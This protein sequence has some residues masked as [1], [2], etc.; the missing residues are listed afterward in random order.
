LPGNYTGEAGNS[1]RR[2]H[3]C[4]RETRRVGLC[5]KIRQTFTVL[6]PVGTVGIMGDSRGAVYA[7][8]LQDMMPTKGMTADSPPFGYGFLSRTATRI[9]NEVSGITRVTYYVTSRPPGRFE[10][11]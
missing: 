7:H 11:E 2:N 8:A 6:P 1:A 4:R 5:D 3:I 10:W 9:I